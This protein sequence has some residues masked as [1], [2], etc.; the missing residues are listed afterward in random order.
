M[1]GTSAEKAGRSWT[2]VIG[3]AA[4]AV[5]LVAICVGASMAYLGISSSIRAEENLHSTIFVVRL[6]EQFVVEQKRWPRSWE[7]LESLPFSSDTPRPGNGELSVVRIGGQ[8]GYPWPAASNDLQRRVAI[9]FAVDPA[10]VARQDPM[11]FTA[12]KPIGPYYEYRD[13]G[14][15]QSLQA[16]IKEVIQSAAAPDAE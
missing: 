9:D 6:V 11:T 14:F 8:H 16:T 4:L 1:E 2:R 3:W 12:I 7:E 13:Y 5:L 15:V 10:A